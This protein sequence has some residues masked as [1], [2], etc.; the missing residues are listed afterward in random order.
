VRDLNILAGDDLPPRARPDGPKIST[1]TSPSEGVAADLNLS[2]F[3]SRIRELYGTSPEPLINIGRLIISIFGFAAIYIDPTQPQSL[4]TISYDILGGYILYSAV[5][6]AVYRSRMSKSTTYMIITTSID[7]VIVGIL[8]YITGELESPFLTFFTFLLISSAVRWNIRGTIAT[9]SALQIILVLVAIPDLNDGESQANFLIIR[10]VF[11]W[12]IVLMLGYFGAY[13]NRS[14]NRLRDLASWPHEIVPDEKRPWLTSS[15]RHA[16]KVLGAKRII[17]QWRDL[18]AEGNHIAIFENGSCRFIDFHSD[19]LK[20]TI[21]GYSFIHDL[22]NEGSWPKIYSSDKSN[23][24]KHH[25]SSNFVSLRY[26]GT[27]TIFDPNFQDSDAILLLK[28]VASQ[29]AIELEQYALVNEYITSVE[30]QE[31]L[32]IARDIH[33]SVLQSLTAAVIQIGAEQGFGDTVSRESVLRIKD[34]IKDAQKKIRRHISG[35]P[36]VEEGGVPLLEKIERFSVALERQWGC[37]VSTEVIP[38]DL[39][40]DDAMATELCLS[41]SEATANAV[42]HGKADQIA[43]KVECYADVLRIRIDDNGTGGDGA[44]TPLPRSIAGRVADLGGEL[45][46]F[47]LDQGLSLRIV[48]PTNAEPAL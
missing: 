46:V 7:V 27:V 35:E 12:V 23:D 10:S 38:A 42:R 2:R 13:R 25:F 8:S 44:V 33:D 37:M 34:T 15:L 1:E 3:R 41:M 22:E 9:A 29:I 32:K 30:L 43:M 16:A 4:V 45:Q 14:L 26:N 36:M 6:I 20:N 21:D 48:L 11:C 40:M 17:V 47:R 5:L 19:A 31:R 39:L 28:I 24:T 18:D